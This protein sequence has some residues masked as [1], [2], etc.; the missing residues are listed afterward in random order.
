MAIFL[1][2]DFQPENFYECNQALAN[3]VTEVCDLKQAVFSAKMKE[4]NCEFPDAV[5][6]DTYSY[7][8]DMFQGMY[9]ANVEDEIYVG[10]KKGRLYLDDEAYS[11][12]M[13]A[14][15][16][17]MRDYSKDLVYEFGSLTNAG[18]GTMT[19]A[20]SFATY[21]L[22]QRLTREEYE[23]Y[24][25][26]TAKTLTSD[27]VLSLTEEE[28]KRFI[29]LYEML[30]PIDAD[31]MKSI[32][33]I[34]EKEGYAGYEED[35]MNIKVLAYTADEPY[36]S[37]Y[38]DN[39]STVREGELDYTGWSNASNGV[40]HVNL[41]GVTG[42]KTPA[43]YSTFFHETS[44]CI[45]Y[46]LGSE[47]DFT[48][49]YRDGNTDLSL[50]NVLENDVRT[51]IYNTVDDYFKHNSGYTVEQQKA[52]RAYVEDAIMNQVDYPS[53]GNP[54]FAMI[55][56]SDPLVNEKDVNKCYS[57]VIKD[58]QNKLVG[59]AND[60]YGGLTGNTLLNPRGERHAAIR[61]DDGKYRVYWISGGINSDGSDLYITL[62]NGERHDETIDFT[63][64]TQWKNSNL[65][66]SVIMSDADVVYK[67]SIA[68]E[69]FAN[70]MAAN[71]CR[72]SKDL[73]AY[74]FY[75]Q[76][77]IDYFEKML[78]AMY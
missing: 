18:S 56:G 30:Y 5:I 74:N 32:V 68:S 71:L 57:Y 45:D 50:Q 75:Y 33:S 78:E 1:K 2:K 34:F 61:R 73:R 63:D 59:F 49:S 43:T 72:D 48:A 37:V 66:E 64:Q 39:I 25:A 52:I 22:R 27:P 42:Q 9:D 36:K 67:D 29:E 21:L 8:Q 38:I 70:S 11:G 31:N 47:K 12:D 20:D 44:H 62:E 26:L 53:Y 28:K 23:E 6:Y 55:A 54:D 13:E 15:M 14:V 35:L 4:N 46:Y 7:I 76:D 17:D 58:I 19:V 24:E 77:T 40:F 16:E 41:A 51:R 65:D 69:F 10:K 60:N 3:Q